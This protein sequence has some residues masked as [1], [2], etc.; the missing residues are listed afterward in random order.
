MNQSYIISIML[1]FLNLFLL[2][3]N[4]RKLFLLL[5]WIAINWFSKYFDLNKLISKSIENFIFLFIIF[6]NSLLFTN[7]ILQ[8]SILFLNNLYLSNINHL[9]SQIIFL[10]H[11]LYSSSM[12]HIHQF[13]IIFSIHNLYSW[14]INYI[15]KIFNLSFKFLISIQFLYSNLS[16]KRKFV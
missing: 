10:Y 12:N 2:I 6:H 9:K 8:F 3:F 1:L 5:L 13:Q 7:H 15:Y 4:I 16:S 11:N 14:R